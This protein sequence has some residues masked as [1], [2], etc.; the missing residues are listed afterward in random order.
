VMSAAA[1]ITIANQIACLRIFDV[2]AV[3]P[4]LTASAPLPPS[5][6]AVFGRR[7]APS[8]IRLWT[9]PSASKRTGRRHISQ[10]TGRH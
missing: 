6:S 9:P 2:I 3:S 8:S 1:L 7:K 10:P 4:Y 5:W